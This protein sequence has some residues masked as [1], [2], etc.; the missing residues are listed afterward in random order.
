LFLCTVYVNG[1]LQI[2][3][4]IIIISDGH[5]NMI[6]VGLCCGLRAKLPENN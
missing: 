3:I 4:I 6:V 2:I 5:C 1:T